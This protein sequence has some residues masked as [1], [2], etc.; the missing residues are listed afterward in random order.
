MCQALFAVLG[1]LPCKRGTKIPAVLIQPI[2]QKQSLRQIGCMWFIRQIP[3]G[4][5][6]QGKQDGLGDSTKPGNGLAL[7]MRSSG[8][9][10]ASQPWA[11]VEA[12]GNGL[13]YL[14]QSVVVYSLSVS[15]EGRE[16]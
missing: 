6:K 13:L 4:E 15:R 7:S 3:S 2:P 5:K 14:H 16:A 12:K 9:F 10:I 11:F 8:A 1:R